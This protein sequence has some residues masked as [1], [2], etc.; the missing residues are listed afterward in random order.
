MRA[1]HMHLKFDACSCIEN[2]KNASLSH[3]TTTHLRSHDS[4]Y[5]QERIVFLVFS[6]FVRRATVLGFAVT[7]G[8]AMLKF[9]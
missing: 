2:M 7:A 6:I 8:L 4:S 5:S 3:M 9:P 1:G